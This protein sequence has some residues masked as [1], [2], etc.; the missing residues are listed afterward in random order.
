MIAGA[1][2]KQETQSNISLQELRQNLSAKD[3]A[4]VWAL[5]TGKSKKEAYDEVL[6]NDKL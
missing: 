1:E 4:F 6:A 3:T 5:L 2:K